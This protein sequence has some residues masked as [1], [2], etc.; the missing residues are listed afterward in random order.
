M[1]C[2][3]KWYVVR[4]TDDEYLVMYSN[5]PP[6]SN[7]FLSPESYPVGTWGYYPVYEGVDEK[8]ANE[9]AHDVTGLK[10]WEQK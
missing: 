9:Y 3:Y 7:S 4:T 8:D 1:C 2:D 5:T 6:Y 10:C